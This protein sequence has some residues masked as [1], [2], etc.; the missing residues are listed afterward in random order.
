[1]P[2]VLPGEP[3]PVLVPYPVPEPTPLP[4]VVPVPVVDEPLRDRRLLLDCGRE[5]VSLAPLPVVPV[6]PL[7]VVPVPDRSLVFP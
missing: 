7:P 6:D 4:V 5:P 2:V 1:M 3:D